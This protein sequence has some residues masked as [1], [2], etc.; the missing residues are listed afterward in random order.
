ME[1]LRL[2]AQEMRLYMKLMTGAARSGESK[3]GEG[4]KT[5]VTT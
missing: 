4:T 1:R 3:P 5:S 2:A